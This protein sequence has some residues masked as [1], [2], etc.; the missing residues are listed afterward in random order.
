VLLFNW[1]QERRFRRKAEAAFRQEQHQDVLLE[2]R[3]EPQLAREPLLVQEQQVVASAA[4]AEPA[5]HANSANAPAT[6]EVLPAGIDPLIDCVITIA[7]ADSVAGETVQTAQQHAQAL[8]KAAQ[9]YGLNAHSQ[10]WEA[11]QADGRYAQ[12]KAA[13]QMADRN[14][15]L[16]SQQFEQF[17]AIWQE[18]A[19]AA[20]G[21]LE[22]PSV[23]AVLASARD[24]DRFGSQVD[25]EIGLNVVAERDA[26]FSATKVRVLA[27]SAGFGLGADGVFYFNDEQGRPLFALHNQGAPFLPEQV[28]SMTT[29]G[30]T[31]VFEVPKVAEGWRV[32]DRM[33][34]LAKNIAASL[35]GILVD[36]KRVPLNDAGIEAIRNPLR[37]IYT[38]MESNKIPAGNRRALRLFS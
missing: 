25:V 32:F 23:Q 3:I 22:Y 30:I 6:A 18:L 19:D 5:D 35:N 13:I 33:V 11:P 26:V 20:H 27:E 1:M 14:G 36:D 21:Q 4:H 24:L 37:A 8:G 2:K 34:T 38:S 17:C 12:V 10:D 16:T 31:F 9:Y 28:R 29:T 15:P 7:F